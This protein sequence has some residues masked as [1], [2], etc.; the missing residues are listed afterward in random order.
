[1][2]SLLE[3]ADIQINGDRPWDIQLNAHGVIE[4]A[5]ARGNLGLGERY[6]DGD[7]DAEHLDEFFFK[8]MRAR[9]PD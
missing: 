7:W 8:L 4:D 9:L 3:K 1:M 6:M 2:A 5:L